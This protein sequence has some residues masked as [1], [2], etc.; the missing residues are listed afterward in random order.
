MAHEIFPKN[1]S[2][3]SESKCPIPLPAQL[4]LYQRREIL[5]KLA[6]LGMMLPFL[7][8]N[9]KTF[10]EVTSSRSRE[11][12]AQAALSP[13]SSCEIL[14]GTM[15][16]D[17]DNTGDWQLLLG[18]GAITATVTA[19]DGYDNGQAIQLNYD[20]GTT[21]GAWVQV[22]RDFDPPLDLSTGDH[23]RFLYHGTTPNAL[24]VGLVSPANENYFGSSWNE[25]THVP[26]WTYATWDFQDFRQSGQPFPDF[27]QI[28]A[29]FI[30]VVKAGNSIGGV[31]SFTIDKLQHLNLASRSIPPNF[32]TSLPDPS[33]IQSAAMWVA[34]QQ[35]PNGL[36]KSWQEEGENLAWLYDQALGLLVLD[37]TDKPRADQL[38]AKLH[39]LQNADGSW[40]VG[41]DYSADAPIETTQPTG[42]NA[43]MVYA[44]SQYA[45]RNNSTTAQ[46]DAQK[47]SCWLANLQR[48]DGSLPA[49]PGETT[50]PTEPN[51]D[52][53]WA[54]NS[55][56]YQKQADALR[57]Y[58]LQEVWDPIIGRFKSSGNLYQDRYRIFLDNQT[59]GAAFL[60]AIGEDEKARQALSYARW[61]LATLPK[62]ENVCGLDGAGPFSIWNEG[63]LQYIVAQ[64]ENSQYYWEQVVKQQAQDGGIPGSPDNFQAYIVW[65]SK[66][67]GLAPTCW[68]YFA[69]TNGPFHVTGSVHNSEY[70]VIY[71][72]QNLSGHSVAAECNPGG[73]TSCPCF[74]EDVALV[75]FASHG[76]VTSN[77]REVNT[78]VNAIGYKKFV[79]TFPN[80]EAIK[81]GVYKYTGQVRLP[82]LPAPDVSQQENPDAVHM[83][84]QLWDG[85]NELYESNKTTLEATIFWSLNPWLPDY[86]SI[87]VYNKP[88]DLVDVGITVTPDTDWHAFELVADLAKQ[89][90]VSI[91]IDDATKCLSHLE[92]A[93]VTKPSWGDEVSLAIT[94]ESLAS[95]PQANC[96]DIFT[97]TTHF[98]DLEFKMLR[99]DVYLPVLSND[100]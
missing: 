63:T 96:S 72:S 49:L 32:E 3:D 90:Y 20:L 31:G 7:L 82:I 37:K 27:N 21:P 50:T 60:K 92:L 42:A 79:E 38:V 33:V 29:I 100:I 26:W 55:T 91:T 22:R 81:L 15:I 41:Y 87:K 51:L 95:W 53:W 8:T 6:G 34:A 9:R 66:W 83:M 56:G 10:P 40:Y 86:G 2:F 84:I 43:W 64:G 73:G 88:L 58:L 25:A 1:K 28:K 4:Q 44:L 68:F 97:W 94:T 48:P 30:S 54:F 39:D 75:S 52:T 65:L 45:K 67:H 59:W 17:M 5:R 80:G 93:Q 24:E 85:R 78:Y 77:V 35:Q 57:D 98:R 36:L 18:G 14:P 46:E 70:K 99:Y 62:I 13:G 76:E 11:E 12:L 23:L 47:G 16:D 19:V 89:K 74:D 69:G 61:T 71:T